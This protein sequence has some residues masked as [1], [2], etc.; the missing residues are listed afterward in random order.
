ML[1]LY[2]FCVQAVNDEMQSM[3]IA[4]EIEREPYNQLDYEYEL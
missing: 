2:L 3:L 1:V 4:E